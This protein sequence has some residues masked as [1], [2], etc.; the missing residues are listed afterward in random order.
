MARLLLVGGASC[1]AL[2]LT[3]DL[4]AEGHAVRSVTRTS[5]HFERIREAGGEAI[6]GDPDVIGTLRYALDNVTLLLWLLGHVEREE[7]HGSR[8]AMMLEKTI[9]TTVRGVVYEAGPEEGVATVE[10]VAGYN[11]IP[12][13]IVPLG[14]DLRGAVDALL[15]R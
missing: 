8:L 14:G 1:R 2:A 11:E 5:D 4:T 15:A 6:L 7:L 13:R 9:D 3:R 12:Y 10:K